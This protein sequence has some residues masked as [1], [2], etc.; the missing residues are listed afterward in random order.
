MADPIRLGIPSLIYHGV[1]PGFLSWLRHTN[2][3]HA[4]RKQQ[5]TT[6]GHFTHL[7]R[8]LISISGH[9]THDLSFLESPM[10]L[11][12]VTARIVLTFIFKFNHLGSFSVRGIRQKPRFVFLHIGSRFSQLHPLP[13]DLWVPFI[14]TLVF[15][16]VPWCI[17]DLSVFPLMCLF[18]GVTIIPHHVYYSSFLVYL[19]EMWN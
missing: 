16:Y 8:V 13:R 12:H 2:T 4:F 9:R 5:K 15:P 11:A 10:P 18:D 6:W 1:D 19:F 14:V 17:L 3:Q 7:F